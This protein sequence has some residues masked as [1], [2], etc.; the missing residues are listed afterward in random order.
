[1]S[2]CC[3]VVCGP[4]ICFNRMFG[5]SFWRFGSAARCLVGA[6]FFCFLMDEPR[7]KSHDFPPSQMERIRMKELIF[8][9]NSL[10]TIGSVDPYISI[11]KGCVT[12]RSY[13]SSRTPFFFLVWGYHLPTSFICCCCFTIDK[14]NI[15]LWT[16]SPCLLLKWIF[17]T[18]KV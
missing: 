11:V 2:S 12:S 6:T 7:F 10:K 18:I 14:R 13:R 1:M 16:L 3:A 9:F 5:K 17:N 15:R 8:S 4:R